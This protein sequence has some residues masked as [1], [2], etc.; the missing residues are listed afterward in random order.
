MY[1]LFLGCGYSVVDDIWEKL[2]YVFG[3]IIYYRCILFF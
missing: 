1:V 2:Y 3:I